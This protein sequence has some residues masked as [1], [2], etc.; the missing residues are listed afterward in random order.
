MGWVMDR[1]SV[2]QAP[3]AGGA[4]RRQ[5]HLL[6]KIVGTIALAAFMISA[7]AGTARALG[8]GE[9]VEELP[10]DLG[11]GSTPAPESE[12]PIAPE[13][14]SQAAGLGEVVEDITEVV[15]EP[16]SSQP[17][18]THQ[19]APQN[20]V[21][22]IVAPVTG[23]IEPVT[24]VIEPVAEVI[25]E[26]VGQM[27]RRA[28]ESVEPV[29]E[30]ARAVV[31]SAAD[32]I[33][34]PLTGI[35]QTVSPVLDEIQEPLQPVLGAVTTTVEKTTW[36][37]DEVSTPIFDGVDDLVDVTLPLIPS[38][39]DLLGGIDDVLDSDRDNGPVSSVPGSPSKDPGTA[40][41]RPDQGP[42]RSI[43]NPPP[44]PLGSL[45]PPPIAPIAEPPGHTDNPKHSPISASA[46]THSPSWGASGGT[47]T[48]WDD[49]PPPYDPDDAAVPIRTGV[50]AASSPSSSSS[51]STSGLLAV[52]VL[53][54][55][56][57]PR[58]S[59]W[60]RPRPVL[61]RPFALAE[62]LELPG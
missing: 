32:A 2:R 10:V 35:I 24:E 27:T 4:D 33:E 52:L 21:N 41:S 28:I 20:P 58:L 1:Q 36:L 23:V 25:E 42:S 46:A 26:P 5:A 17:A 3:T 12:Q 45:L 16:V 48:T 40:I 53:L 38:P 39:D 8:I 6:A 54:G 30:T 7:S 22:T 55:L 14:A 49:P 11:I 47:A 56:I 18:P 19:S 31:D 15:T 51:G 57:A 59:R 9:I 62:A 13:Q 61:W 44:P 29:T 37:V 43:T 60:L 34:E 50:V